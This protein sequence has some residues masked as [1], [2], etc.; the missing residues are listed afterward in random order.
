MISGRHA[1][2]P[3]RIL[4]KCHCLALRLWCSINIALHWQSQSAQGA[5]PWNCST[6]S[7][8]SRTRVLTHRGALIGTIPQE[9]KS[10]LY[11]EPVSPLHITILKYGSL[12][13]SLCSPLLSVR[14]LLKPICSGSA[15]TARATV[16]CQGTQSQGGTPEQALMALALLSHPPH[17]PWCIHA[18]HL[19]CIPTPLL[20][21]K[22][23]QNLTKREQINAAEK[24]TSNIGL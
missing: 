3:G 8:V 4:Q 13:N 11:F 6:V 24:P 5:H 10:C 9:N 19:P 18:W 21:V 17:P 12:N 7:A 22:L 16:H 2:A 1:T 23:I 20:S 15:C 14:P